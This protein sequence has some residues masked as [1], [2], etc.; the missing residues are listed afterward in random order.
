[1]LS[2]VYR[3]RSSLPFPF[4]SV[5]LQRSLLPTKNSS[6]SVRNIPPHI[7]YHWYVFR[8]LGE[9]AELRDGG[10]YCLRLEE[11]CAS[12]RAHRAGD[13]VQL[14][15]DTALSEGLN[16]KFAPGKRSI[17]QRVFC[18][19][20]GRRAGGLKFWTKRYRARARFLWWIIITT[21]SSGSTR[22]AVRL[23][24]PSRPARGSRT[25]AS[26]TSGNRSAR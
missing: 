6:L 4:S 15:R 7:N 21:V 14:Y 24:S 12:G 13:K 19:G 3:I 5:T 9:T 10:T 16:N 11:R 17:N 18:L 26:A 2:A 23:R 8:A 1:M 25:P 20:T 22:G